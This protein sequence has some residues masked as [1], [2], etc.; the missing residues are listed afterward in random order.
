ML[1]EYKYVIRFIDFGL[2]LQVLLDVCSCGVSGGI[3]NYNDAVV[4]VILHDYGF[5]VAEM[6]TVGS[7]IK[8]GHY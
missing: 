1:I 7:V 3:V 8:S 4:S 2:A 6:A 5:N